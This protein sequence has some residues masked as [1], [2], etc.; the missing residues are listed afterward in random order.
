MMMRSL[1]TLYNWLH[2]YQK[3]VRKM[4]RTRQWTSQKSLVETAFCGATIYD[5][6]RF[7]EHRSLGVDFSFFSKF[8]GGFCIIYQETELVLA[9]SYDTFL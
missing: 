9:H 8:S 5:K 2:I 1:N 4:E 3:I 7:I 6:V